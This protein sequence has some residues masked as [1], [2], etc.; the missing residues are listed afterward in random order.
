MQDNLGLLMM[1]HLKLS[2]MFIKISN[3][4]LINLSGDMMEDI[5]LFFKEDISQF[6]IYV[7]EQK[8]AIG[9]GLE[10]FKSFKGKSNHIDTDALAQ[11][12]IYKIYSWIDKRIPIIADLIKTVFNEFSPSGLADLV[13]ALN[14]LSGTQ[15]HQAAG[16]EVI[17]PIIIQEGKIIKKYITQLINLHKNSFLTPTIIILLKDNDFDRAK[18][19]L[20]ECPNGMRVK[21]IRNTGASELYKIINTGADD[22]NSFINFFAE[23]C[24]STCSQTK[25]DI[26]LNKEW[27]E[28]S[29]VKL[30]TPRLLK[31]RANLLCD[32]KDEIKSYLNDYI[33][34]LEKMD[35]LSEIDNTLRKN[36]L[37]IA[38]LYRV[39]CN[40]SGSTDMYDALMIAQELNNQLLLAYVYK[41]AYFFGNKSISEQSQL[42]EEAYN[43]FMRNNMVDNAVYCKNNMLVRQFDDGAIRAKEFSEMLGEAIGG[44]PGLVG[45]SHIYNNTGL[46]YMMSA[47][48][49][50]ALELF[51]KGLEYS[52]SVDRKVQYFAILCN[53]LITEV[54]Y[55]K[56]IEFSDLKN[57]FTKI[58]D[59][60]VRN[61]QL[62]FISARYIMNLLIIALKENKNWG[63]ELIQQYDIIGLINDGFANNTLG[64]GQLIMQLDYIEQKLP[65][66]NIKNQC[67]TPTMFI[68]PT[69]RRKEFIERTGLNP[70]YF[71]TWL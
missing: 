40:D 38:K 14:K 61:N 48:P 59:G 52:K 13:V 26:L 56:Y 71:F 41:Y 46:A 39:F 35:S 68:K 6:T 10:Y 25:H 2:F 12:R 50:Y 19:L 60:M 33:V 32:D 36:F 69:G 11:K 8:F 66:C 17:D 23:Q 70:F 55:G 43:I 9:R 24:F 58:F 54:Y 22:I 3:T 1:N 7:V 18:E 57:T 30:Y 67:H 5:R 37:C 45:M 53:K 15:I 51:D 62:P 34:Q 27:S 31:Y 47:Q 42:L 65:E 63:K 21:F 28:N 64:N 16:P 4:I 44:V 49:D 29:I 20:C